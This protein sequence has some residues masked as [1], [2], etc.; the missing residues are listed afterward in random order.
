[1]GHRRS[2]PGC[3]REMPILAGVVAPPTGTYHHCRMAVAPPD[4]VTIPATDLL[5]RS[6]QLAA[7]RAELD[8]VL[9]GSAGRLVLV[10][11]EAGI[12]KTAL[13]QAFCRELSHAVLWGACDALYTP[14]PLGPLLDIAPGVG[15]RFAELVEGGALPHDVATALLREL[16]SRGPTVLVL[17]DVHWA[18]GATLDVL[19]LLVRRL[20]GVPTLV[21]ASYRDTEVGRFHP[22]RQVLGELPTAGATRLRLAPFTAAAVAILAAPYDADAEE[23]YRATGGNPFFVT[24]AL[25]SGEEKMPSTIR[26]AVLAHAA[27]LGPGAR[28]LLEAVAVSPPQAELWLL[29]AVVPTSLAAIDECLASGMLMSADAAL[30]FR[31]ELARLA[32][33]EA[34]APDR[35]LALHRLVLSAL[36]QAPAHVTEARIAHH[37]EGAGDREAVLRLAPAAGARA[38][39]LGAHREAAAQF[40]RALRFADALPLDR[41]ARLLQRRSYECYLTADD[42]EALA[43]T[44]EALACY[45]QLGNRVQQGAELRWRGLVLSNLGRHDEAVRSMHEAVDLLERQPPGRELAMAYCALAGAFTLS[46]D[47]AAVVR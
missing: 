26:D 10:S 9:T 3:G 8:E 21:C 37:A 2:H 11:G 24:E 34:I 30:A 36:A 18:D 25:A 43:A 35:G 15:G 45:R 28:D 31:H 27:R 46:E 6:A 38:S 17:E 20:T 40:Q 22:F 4:R 39:S 13:L 1:M 44:E 47:T 29:E 5:E 12:G 32:I 33:E 14:R 16:G 23:L 7:L 42:E 41:R 19:R